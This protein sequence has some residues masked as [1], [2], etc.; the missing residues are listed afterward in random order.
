MKEW[1]PLDWAAVLV[2][3]LPLCLF[4]QLQKLWSS[5]SSLLWLDLATGMESF[6][7]FYHWWSSSTIWAHLILFFFSAFYHL[8][9]LSRQQQCQSSHFLSSVEA[10]IL[11]GLLSPKEKKRN[12]KLLQ[13]QVSAQ[14]FYFWHYIFRT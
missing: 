10:V 3:L 4:T 7:I 5:S 12:T 6:L 14:A 13:K 9:V 1:I 2:C 11:L 8:A